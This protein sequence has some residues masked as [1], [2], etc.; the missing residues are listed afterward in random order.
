MT[1]FGFLNDT[2]IQ[3]SDF[4]GLDVRDAV[5]SQH[6]FDHLSDEIRVKRFII[7]RDLEAENKIK[8]KVEQA[9]DYYLSLKK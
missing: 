1:P 2:Q 4:S 9:N 7:D 3:F 8:E 6:N 5:Q